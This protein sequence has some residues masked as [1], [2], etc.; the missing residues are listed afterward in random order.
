MNTELNPWIIRFRKERRARKESQLLLISKTRE[1]WQI[2]KDFEKKINEKTSSLSIALEEAQ[3]ANNTKSTI[4]ANISHELKTPLNSINVI[5]NVMLNNKDNRLN[6]LEKNNLKIINNCGNDLLYLVNNILDISIIEAGKIELSLIDFNF[7]EN[8]LEIKE[9]FEPQT[10]NKN[11]NFICDFDSTIG[12]IHNDKNK[13]NQIIKNLLSN[14]LKFVKEG[15]ILLQ[16]KNQKDKILIIVQ[17]TGIGIEQKKLNTIFDRFKQ[18]DE[19]INKKYGG[20][21]LGLNITKELLILLNGRIGIKSKINEGSTFVVEIPKNIYKLSNEEQSLNIHKNEILLFHND[22]ISFFPISVELKKH[23]IINQTCD[24]EEFIKMIK[25]K[26]YLFLIIDIQTR[27][28]NDIELILDDLSS[29]IIIVYDTE[30][31]SIFENRN[32]IFSKKPIEIQLLISEI[33]KI[34]Q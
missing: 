20:T 17:D 3:K 11:I 28:I 2:K 26:K 18:A 7:N 31:P 12:Y 29:N 22:P 6:E 27:D 19:S 13:I 34:K 15:Y 16:V 24:F 32:F 23:Y 14:S 25:I 1:L 4:L 5:S 10:N 8:L 33:N 30:I 21:G 9:M